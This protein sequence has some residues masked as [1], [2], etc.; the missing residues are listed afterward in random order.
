MPRRKLSTNVIAILLGSSSAII[1][2]IWAKLRESFLDISY[3]NI[4]DG[5][6]TFMIFFL[7]GIFGLICAIRKEMPQ[8]WIMLK[9]RPAVI[10]GSLLAIVSWFLA[11][12]AL[13]RSFFVM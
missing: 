10:L 2:V 13:Y 12:Y 6:V 8:G 11:L 4:I 5:L 9:G 7:F 1:G 3:I